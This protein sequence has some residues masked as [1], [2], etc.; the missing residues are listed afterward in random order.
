MWVGYQVCPQLM[1]EGEKGNETENNKQVHKLQY[2]SA[3][4]HW[5]G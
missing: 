4:R 5:V 2:E 1:G 3:I